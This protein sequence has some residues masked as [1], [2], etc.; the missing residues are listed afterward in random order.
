MPSI[1]TTGEQQQKVKADRLIRKLLGDLRA[2]EPLDAAYIAWVRFR[3]IQE[4]LSIPEVVAQITT[5]AEAVAYYLA[6]PEVAALPA[7][8]KKVRGRDIEATVMA[9]ALILSLID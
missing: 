5:R 2:E 7:S 8:E 9:F 3:G 1:S 6:I 4:G